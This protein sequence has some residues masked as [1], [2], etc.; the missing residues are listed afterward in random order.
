M[1]VFLEETFSFCFKTLRLCE[2]ACLFVNGMKFFR[3]CGLFCMK[4]SLSCSLCGVSLVMRAR[5][6]MAAKHWLSTPS[7]K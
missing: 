4:S 3:H 7:P 6:R 1:K 5:A 2:R